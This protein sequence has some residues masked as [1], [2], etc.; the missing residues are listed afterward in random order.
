IAPQRTSTA[1]VSRSARCNRRSCRRVVAFSR[2]LEQATFVES[3]PPHTHSCL[4]RDQ[5]LWRKRMFARALLLLLA[6]HCAWAGGS[7]SI[8]IKDLGAIEGVK[9]LD[10]RGNY[11]GRIA[12]KFN[13]KAS[14]VFNKDRFVPAGLSASSS[15]DTSFGKVVGTVTVDPQGKAA[16]V[17]GAIRN[18]ELGTFSTTV[19]ANEKTGG[20]LGPL[21]W[22]SNPMSFP[23]A[24]QE[25]TPM[26]INI[27]HDVNTKEGHVGIAAKLN[28]NFDGKLMLPSQGDPVVT[29]VGSHSPD[30]ASDIRASANVLE[31]MGGGVGKGAIGM[32]YRR[33]LDAVPVRKFARL[34]PPSTTPASVSSR[35]TKIIHPYKL[36]Q[37][38]SS[39]VTLEGKDTGDFAWSLSNTSK[40]VTLVLSG[41]GRVARRGDGGGVASTVSLRQSFRLF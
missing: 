29:L 37:G 24:V 38:S 25:T 11:D 36:R 18:E 26:V 16:L 23:F 17:E 6:P 2:S 1:F 7:V 5:K 9:S 15:A 13:G 8:N 19:K 14:Y 4:V 20:V 32:S 22:M 21:K 30:K 3:W 28:S 27:A 31:L 39:R 35:R 40:R 41:R 10:I 12:D 33:D 34:R